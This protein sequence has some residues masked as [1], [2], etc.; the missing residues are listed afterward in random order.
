MADRL[1]LWKK[2][3]FKN[4]KIQAKKFWDHVIQEENVFYNIQ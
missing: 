3:F 4:Y 1:K 2:I